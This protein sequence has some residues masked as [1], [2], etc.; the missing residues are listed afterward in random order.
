MGRNSVEAT[1]ARRILAVRAARAARLPALLRVFFFAFFDFFAFFACVA[2]PASAF[3]VAALLECPTGGA[4][5]ISAESTAASHREGRRKE[6]EG[7]DKTMSSLYS[8][9]VRG[10]RSREPALSL[11]HRRTIMAK[12]RLHKRLLAQPV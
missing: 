2:E 10:A 8:A 1:K 6:D 7:E 4:N 5:T 3:P 12:P 9:F 11:R